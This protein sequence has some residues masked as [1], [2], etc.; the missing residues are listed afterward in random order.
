MRFVGQ[1]AWVGQDLI[2]IAQP[3]EILE[4][5]L[6][7]ISKYLVT[8]NVI[9]GDDP[10]KFLQVTPPVDLKSEINLSL[11]DKYFGWKISIMT[12]CKNSRIH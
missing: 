4:L 8:L 6:I 3:E 5:M 11:G 7:G 1:V 9:N 2:C 12:L 10:G